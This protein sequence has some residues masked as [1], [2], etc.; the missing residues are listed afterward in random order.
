MVLRSSSMPIRG[1]RARKFAPPRRPAARAADGVTLPGMATAEQAE[2][3]EGGGAAS[4]TRRV[5]G[6][7]ALAAVGVILLA[8]IHIAGDPLGVAL[9]LA[10][11]AFWAGYVVLGH[12]VAAD[13]GLRPNDGLAAGMIIGAVVVAP[14]LIPRA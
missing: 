6:A 9:A 11:G 14:A 10:A 13:R 12:R 2:G 5:L 7:L 4:L 8:D 3:P 1:A